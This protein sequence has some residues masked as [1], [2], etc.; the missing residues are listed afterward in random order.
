MNILALNAGSES[1]KYKL[2]RMPEMGSDAAEEVLLGGSEDHSAGGIVEASEKVLKACAKK[3]VDAIGHRVVQGGTL[4]REPTRVSPD[5]LKGLHE[6]RDLDPTHNP[7]ETAMIEAGSRLLPGV[8]AFALFDTSFHRTLPEVAWRYALPRDLSDRWH[9]RRYGFHGLSH[10]YVAEALLRLLKRKP[11]GTRLIVC[12]L[13]NGA[14]VCALK[15]GR[16]VDT[17]MGMTPL[18]GLVMGTRSGDVDPGLLMYLLRTAH[19]TAKAVDD[20]L[21][22]RSG[23]LGLSGK[24]ADVRQLVILSDKGSEDAR[25]ALQIFAYRVRK[26]IGAYAAVLGG[27]DAVAFTGGI[28]EHSAQMRGRI[29]EGLSFLGIHLDQ[30]ANDRVGTEE[31]CISAAHASTQIWVIPTDEEREMA[32]QVWKLLGGKPL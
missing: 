13:G 25:L 31:A 10:Q 16:S 1:L 11:E 4:F 30:A 26:Y 21:N 12:H 24:S 19:M 22:L 2:F 3:G 18:E 7:T 14:S 28:G 9:L 20:A 8:P 27:V 23:L 15:D 6:L 32:R 5:L 17:S 29:C